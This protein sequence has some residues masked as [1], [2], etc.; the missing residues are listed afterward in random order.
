MRKAILNTCSS[1]QDNGLP[2]KR[3]GERDKEKEG[4][5]GFRFRVSVP[6]A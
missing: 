2:M 1:V 4:E 5:R 3:E 6:F